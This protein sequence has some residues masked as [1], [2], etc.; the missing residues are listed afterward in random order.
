MGLYLCVF[1]SEV[2]DHEL[3]GIDAGGYDDFNA[4]RQAVA[5]HLE[6]GSW[7]SR[8]PVLMAHVDSDGIWAPDDLGA[9][10]SELLLIAKG[11]SQEPPHPPQGGWQFEVIR[12]K[13]LRPTTL[14]ESFFDVDGRPLPDALLELV[15][16][17]I[18][19]GR[20]IWFQ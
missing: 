3:L 9:L 11:L 14:G 19:S 7:G 20:S 8:F 16:V 13:G 17:A 1:D 12:E 15:E 6:G 18:R 2:D 5:E 10:R 4:F